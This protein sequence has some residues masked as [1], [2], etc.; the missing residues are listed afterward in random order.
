MRLKLCQ[1]DCPGVRGLVALTLDDAPCRGEGA[2]LREVQAG[3]DGER[4][5]ATFMTEMK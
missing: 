3:S 1:G 2:M 5:V 4:F